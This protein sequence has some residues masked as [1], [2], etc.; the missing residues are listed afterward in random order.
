MLSLVKGVTPF[1][2]GLTGVGYGGKDS[3]VIGRVL[4]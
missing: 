1:L 4:N 3:R 2:N